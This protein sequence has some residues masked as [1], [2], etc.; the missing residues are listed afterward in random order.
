MSLPIAVLLHTRTQAFAHDLCL[1]SARTLLL[2]VHVCVISSQSQMFIS[3]KNVCSVVQN[4]AAWPIPG[5]NLK[6][7]CIV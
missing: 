5:P 6:S 1:T 2:F 4:T 7:K 3:Q